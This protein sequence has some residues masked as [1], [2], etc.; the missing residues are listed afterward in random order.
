MD[1]KIVLIT[2]ATKGIGRATSVYL[3]NQDWQVIGIARSYI[4][5]FPGELFLCDL[6][7]ENQTASFIT[8]QV[9]CVDGGGS[10]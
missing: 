8:E 3:Y 5:D 6:A 10:L 7:D 4:D 1:N 9:I 2:G